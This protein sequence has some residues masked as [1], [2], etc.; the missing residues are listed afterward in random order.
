MAIEDPSVEE[1]LRY[2]NI[3]DNLDIYSQ[4]D[5]FLK[6]LFTETYCDN[7]DVYQ[8]MVKVCMLNTIYNTNIH[9]PLLVANHIVGLDVDNQIRNG[10]LSIINDFAKIKLGNT[11]V[12]RYYSF[13]TKYCS[14]HNPT[15]YPV[16]D[17]FVGKV[18]LYFRDANIGSS[19]YNFK[20]SDFRDYEKFVNILCK[21]RSYYGLEQFS[22]KDLDKYL[23]QIGKKHFK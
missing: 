4:P 2:V 14:F 1:V 23:W 5:V 22:Y 18:L 3:W 16:Y 11:K 17:S 10:N 20:N 13:A 9:H 15:S 6:K 21:F 8:V 19:F 12:V 7:V